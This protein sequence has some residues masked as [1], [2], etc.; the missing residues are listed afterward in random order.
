MLCGQPK[1]TGL[2]E[3]E[4][5]FQLS[6]L[7]HK[8]E[9]SSTQLQSTSSI[10]AS[11]NTT[12]LPSLKLTARFT[13]WNT[14]VGSDDPFLLVCLSY[15]QRLYMLV[16]GAPVFPRFFCDDHIIRSID[17]W[18]IRI[19]ID[20]LNKRST[21]IM[22]WQ[23]YVQVS[24]FWIPLRFS[25]FTMVHLFLK[26][27]LMLLRMKMYSLNC[28]SSSCTE[29]H[30]D[31]GYPY[32]SIQRQNLDAKPL[33]VFWIVS[34]KDDTSGVNR[35]CQAGDRFTFQCLELLDFNAWKK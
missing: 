13:P 16:S 28:W 33:P 2:D 9:F 10:S 5:M 6:F 8:P 31:S 21:G 1:S 29:H 34:H 12:S 32:H 14:G 30:Q 26:R 24:C 3:T 4:G 35:G 27:P 11:K 7:A 23:M 22:F 15:F 17:H 25:W 18:Y 20:L 19:P